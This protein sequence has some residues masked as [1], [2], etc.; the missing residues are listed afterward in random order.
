MHQH[1]HHHHVHGQEHTHH[2]QR[3]WAR[4]VLWLL[5]PCV[6]YLA[7][8]CVVFV[9]ETEFALITRMG[10]KV[11]TV[12]EPGL[13]FKLPWPIDRVR[14]RA[15][16]FDRRLQVLEMRA[17]ERITHD[18][19]AL[20]V[21]SFVCWKIDPANVD[22]YFK[23]VGTIGDANRR[24]EDLA[25]AE[26]SAAIGQRRL[27][28]LI[29]V[30]A[31]AQNEDPSEVETMM[32]ELTGRL[33]QSAATLG[34]LV[35]DVRLRRFNYPTD[36]KPAIYERI[37]S[38]RNRFAV[39]YRSEGDTEAQKIRSQAD[40]ER[41]KLL[42]DAE[43]EATRIRGKA[44]AD[45]SRILNEAHSK[46]PEF[47]ALI[48]TLDAYRKIL[49]DKT[50]LILSTDNAIF[51]MLTQRPASPPAANTT[52]AAKPANGAA[53]PTKTKNANGSRPGGP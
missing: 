2:R 18:K 15:D 19:K 25:A 42:A 39:Q 30:E 34:I 10:A 5:L 4:V 49:D 36:V 20:T 45:K 46:D 52:L 17:L 50:T 32:A 44:D 12:T 48:R 13:R 9:D 14:R 33:R 43:A 53:M 47:F 40:L 8:T 31:G 51:Q 1:S 26:L 27:D 3:P 41:D 16:G 28:Q 22:R 37:R 35:E 11:A 21:G 7:S 23:T 38:E 24:L 6:L 29:R